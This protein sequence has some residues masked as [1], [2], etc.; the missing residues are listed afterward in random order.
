MKIEGLEYQSEIGLFC[1]RGEP[2]GSNYASAT[3]RKSMMS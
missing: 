3:T 1:G 2:E